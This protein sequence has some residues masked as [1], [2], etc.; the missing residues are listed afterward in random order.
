M[1][2]E[3]KDMLIAQSIEILEDLIDDDLFIRTYP[4]FYRY[5]DEWDELEGA[6]D[7]PE[8]VVFEFYAEKIEPQEGLE[9]WGT[10]H[11]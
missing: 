5:L 1:T 10:Y 4:S 7:V 3:N 6:W 8:E 2:E 11:G 9:I